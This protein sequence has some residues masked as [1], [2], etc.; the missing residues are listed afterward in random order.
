MQIIKKTIPPLA[1]AV[2]VPV[3]ALA[4]DRRVRTTTPPP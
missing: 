2:L 3:A 4:D 1:L